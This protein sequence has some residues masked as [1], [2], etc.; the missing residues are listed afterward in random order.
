MEQNESVR[1]ISALFHIISRQHAKL[2]LEAFREIGRSIETDSIADIIDSGCTIFK[3]CNG[4]IQTSD[5]DIV[6]SI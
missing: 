4:C 3:H 2:L 5:L 1:R 6:F